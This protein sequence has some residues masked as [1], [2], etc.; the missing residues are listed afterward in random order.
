MNTLKRRFVTLD[1]TDLADVMGVPEGVDG[2]LRT[3]AVRD[4]LRANI[5]RVFGSRYAGGEA[6]EWNFT[7]TCDTDGDWMHL[8]FQR[9]LRTSE[10]KKPST[11]PPPPPPIRL[12]AP[13]KLV[14]SVDTG[15]I[16]LVK[17]TVMLDGNVV[18]TSR[19]GG[20]TRPLSFTFTCKQYYTL[21]GERRR[22]TIQTSRQR[23]DDTSNPRA[24]ELRTRLSSTSLHT[25]M[26]SR[27]LSYMR[28]KLELADVS[29]QVWGR[30][31]NRSAAA[32][33]RRRQT[34]K[35]A[36]ILR[37]F[38]GVQRTVR[39]IT[40]LHEATVVWGVK[41]APTGRGNLSAPTD[42]V[43]LLAARVEGWTIVLGKGRVGR[44]QHPCE[45]DVHARTPGQS[46]PS[47]HGVMNIE[48]IKKPLAIQAWD[49]LKHADGYR[50]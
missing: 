30:A 16:N 39:K 2:A 38:Y 25:G 43:A 32:D 47:F 12:E 31:L 33:R 50:S 21:I 40:G 9:P 17:I 6:A 13:P 23:R 29:E 34:A 27:I 44:E 37:W 18:M 14:L 49:H 11:E 48:S 10:M 45:G 7:G 5:V 24:K 46:T 4:A 1:A 35:D 8:H 3:E 22:S 41:V 19:P 36:S 26:S 42:R 28:A 20:R 15:R